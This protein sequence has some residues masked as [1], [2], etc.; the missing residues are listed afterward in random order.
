M[1]F[2]Q[3]GVKWFYKIV[4][5]LIPLEGGWVG[6][7][8]EKRL[9]QVRCGAQGYTTFPMKIAIDATPGRRKFCAA[10]I[11][12]TARGW[13]FQVVCCICKSTFTK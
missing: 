5:I 12:L 11:A 10:E 2:G 1:D 4:L 3:N 7:W 8:S 13:F 9:E 6:G